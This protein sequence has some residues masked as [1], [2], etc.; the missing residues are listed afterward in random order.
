MSILGTGIRLEEPIAVTDRLTFEPF[1]LPEDVDELAKLSAHKA[2][3]G[4]CCAF[5]DA[6][7]FALR[8]APDTPKAAIVNTWNNSWAMVWL[9]ILIKSPVY[10]PL[11]IHYFDDG[12]API[13]RCSNFYNGAAMYSKPFEINAEALKNHFVLYDDFLS[14][15]GDRRFTHA[16]SVAATNYNEPKGS[17]RVAAIWSAIE[18][19]LGFD[20]ELRFRISASVA[21][22]LENGPEAQ[23]K[24][25]KEVRKLYDLRSKCVHGAAIT[26]EDQENTI[27]D[28]LNLLCELLFLFVEKKS[29]PDKSDIDKV[30]FA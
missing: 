11:T 22:L 16:A 29:I 21:K 4:F 19:L 27:R 9:A 18:A 24:R 6:I 20:H 12:K 13:L 2:D 8:L 5:S 15:V 3:F 17:I 7:S 14:L 28:S 23:E 10:W 26:Q 30:F 1:K 25:F